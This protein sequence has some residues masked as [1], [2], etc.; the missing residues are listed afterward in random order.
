MNT[1]TFCKPMM[2]DM[3]SSHEMAHHGVGQMPMVGRGDMS[4]GM[5]M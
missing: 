3:M 2:M 4:M 1:S 5:I